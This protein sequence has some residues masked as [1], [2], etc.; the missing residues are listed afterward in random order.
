AITAGRLHT[1]A[2]LSD[3]RV[4]CWGK[5]DVGQLGFKGTNAIVGDNEKPSSSHHAALTMFTLTIAAGAKH[6]CTILSPYDVVCFGEG[7]HGRLGYDG[8]KDRRL[9][10]S[11]G[12]TRDKVNIGNERKALQITAGA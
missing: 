2:L 3:W 7:D 12:G 1:C 11:I 5:N 4:R 9:D 6:T 10:E 8:T